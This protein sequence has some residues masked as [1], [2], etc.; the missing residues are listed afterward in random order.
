MLQRAGWVDGPTHP[1]DHDDA[2]TYQRY[3]QPLALPAGYW[4]GPGELRL[5]KAAASNAEPGMYG[6]TDA[7]ARWRRAD[8][9]RRE[10]R[11]FSTV[12]SMDAMGNVTTLE[13]G[14]EQPQENVPIPVDGNKTLVVG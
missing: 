8:R 10:Y 9:R 1:R 12:Q 5:A 13:S 4:T 11:I 6:W 3:R 2:L 7:L 14:P